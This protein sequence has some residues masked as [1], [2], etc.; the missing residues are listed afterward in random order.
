MKI[1]KMEIEKV[2][3]EPIN[4]TLQLESEA[5][6][7]ELYYRYVCDEDISPRHFERNE[8]NKEPFIFNTKPNDL[9][10]HLIDLYNNL[11]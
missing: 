9:S 8:S 3:F 5:D 10:R 1:L 6:L 11:K 7:K 2:I 4:I